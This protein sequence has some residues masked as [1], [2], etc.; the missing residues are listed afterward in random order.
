MKWNKRF[1]KCGQCGVGLKEVFIQMQTTLFRVLVKHKKTTTY[2]F[3]LFPNYILLYVDLPH[4]ILVEYTD[5]FGWSEI[6]CGFI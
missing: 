1:S 5:V 2:F 3:F 6:K 4:Q